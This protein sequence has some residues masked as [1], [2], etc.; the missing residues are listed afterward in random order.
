METVKDL[1]VRVYM[2]VGV[3]WMWPQQESMQAFDSSVSHHWTQFIKS[4][5]EIGTRRY[6]LRRSRELHDIRVLPPP[7]PIPSPSP[8]PFLNSTPSFSRFCQCQLFAH[9]ASM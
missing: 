6:T 7:N 1:P 3:P 9:N 8:N 2:P 5:R 4:P